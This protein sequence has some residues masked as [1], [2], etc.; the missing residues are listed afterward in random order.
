MARRSGRKTIPL[1]G[2]SREEL[3]IIA[4]FACSALVSIANNLKS[5]E[6]DKDDT[7]GEFGLSVPEIIEMAHDDM[8]SRARATLDRIISS[9]SANVTVTINGATHV[10]P[11]GGHA[12]Y[13]R[14]VA[15]AGLTGNPTLTV[16][17]AN[18]DRAGR[19]LIKGETVALDEGAHVTVVHTGNA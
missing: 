12:T 15:L 18:R 4:D 3:L 8:I 13:E 10:I 19:A 2:R 5:E 9:S 14:L 6:G 17:F 11:S 1:I 16:S 7:E